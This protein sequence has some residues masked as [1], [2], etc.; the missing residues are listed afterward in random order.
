MGRK[1]FLTHWWFLPLCRKE[2]AMKTIVSAVTI[3][4]IFLLS[5][6]V[7]FAQDYQS[8][9]A[10]KFKDGSIVR[11]KIIEMN[12]TTIK[13]LKPDGNIETRRYQDVA[14]FIEGPYSGEQPPSRPSVPP[15]P[16]VPPPYGPPP[17]TPYATYYRA[18]ANYFVFKGGVYTPESDELRHF[19]SGFN[20]E[21]AFGHYFHPNF[22]L[23]LGAGYFEV[24]PTY[25]SHYYYGGSSEKDRIWVV[26]I[27]LS[28]KPALQF[29]PFELYALGGGGLY[30]INV[31][32][33]GNL[34]QTGSFSFSD[35][36]SVFGAHLGAGL[37]WNITPRV[38]IGVEGKYIWAEKK[39]EKTVNNT[40][41]QVNADVQG[42]QTTLNLSFR[43]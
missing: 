3:F 6:S 14:S 11:G 2:N 28:L 19:D 37:N 43:F 42:F 20:G 12:P 5:V 29:P 36:G 40:T 33:S 25:R 16:N 32:T 9:T 21:I 27:T 8:I 39:F 1:E 31:E 10:V 30:I 35:N 4:V 34:G 22:A 17:P 24:K 23:E 38:A 41:V 18:P 7:C 13:I 26:P 15:P